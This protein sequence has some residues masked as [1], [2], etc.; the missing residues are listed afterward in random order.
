MLGVL[1]VFLLLQLWFGRDAFRWTCI[2]RLVCAF[3]F[4][5]I[6][7]P[8]RL[9]RP[10]L[11]ETTDKEFK[12]RRGSAASHHQRHSSAIPAELLGCG[13]EL[14]AAEERL[15]ASIEQVRREVFRFGRA[16]QVLVRVLGQV[17]LTCVPE[18]GGGGDGN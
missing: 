4:A 15:A 18:P 6:S 10:P 5:I 3:D 17:V 13:E 16:Q 14:V 2:P 11:Q 7:V 12:T 9:R 1:A 8:N